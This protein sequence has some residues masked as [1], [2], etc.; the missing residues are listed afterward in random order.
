MQKSRSAFQIEIEHDLK[1][2]I[3]FEVFIEVI[4]CL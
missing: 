4:F 1:N 2:M 3:C